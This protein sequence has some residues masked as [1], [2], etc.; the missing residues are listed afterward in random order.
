MYT[1]TVINHHL[2]LPP[3]SMTPLTTLVMMPTSSQLQMESMWDQEKGKYA[4][5]PFDL[6][7][8]TKDINT[9]SAAKH[10]TS[11][12]ASFSLIHPYLSSSPIL[13][14]H[15]HLSSPLLALLPSYQAR[16]AGN[17]PTMSHDGQYYQFPP[18]TMSA[19]ASS[20]H[21]HSSIGWYTWVRFATQRC[22][23]RVLDIGKFCIVY[24]SGNPGKHFGVNF[25]YLW[26]FSLCK[27][28]KV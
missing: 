20:C 8:N 16:C 5:M 15:P 7:D 9:L 10:D 28:L 27:V 21:P 2:C 25:M 12:S 6:H 24:S 3:W 19:A 11:P 13:V 22:I 23:V 4:I 17:P 18:T 14:C 26:I 1:L